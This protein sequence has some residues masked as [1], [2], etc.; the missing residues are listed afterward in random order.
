M[1]I[2]V[3]W[4]RQSRGFPVWLLVGALTLGSAAAISVCLGG[5]GAMVAGGGGGGDC[6]ASGGHGSFLLQLGPHHARAGTFS[7]RVV[8]LI[9]SEP[10]I[11]SITGDYLV[12][13][14][15]VGALC[16]AGLGRHGG[17]YLAPT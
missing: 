4:G 5:R 14:P 3:G 1:K 15:Y 10:R 13:G 12:S 8:G 11:R 2:A 9:W 16:H 7:M 6:L 17:L